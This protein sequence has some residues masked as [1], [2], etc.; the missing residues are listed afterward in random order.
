VPISYGN[1]YRIFSSLSENVAITAFIEYAK[2][3]G[4]TIA[5]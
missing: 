1:E 5:T 4:M 2:S 3:K